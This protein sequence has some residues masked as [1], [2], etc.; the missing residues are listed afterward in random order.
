[1]DPEGSSRPGK[2]SFPGKMGVRF[3]VF[4]SGHCTRG[5]DSAAK[6]GFPPRP[7]IQIQCVLDVGTHARARRVPC[8]GSQVHRGSAAVG[9]E[10]GQRGALL[11]LGG[12][13]GGLYR[14][15]R[16]PAA[17]LWAA[18]QTIHSPV[19]ILLIGLRNSARR[20]QAELHHTHTRLPRA[21]CGT[22]RRVRMFLDSKVAI[23]PESKSIAGFGPGTNL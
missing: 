19:Q 18:E 11:L 13:D 12:R 2:L 21:V 9:G 14:R 17:P 15:A 4:C 3:T 1:M 16:R 23:S 7:P 10:C 6:T 22:V 20:A 5:S 8:P